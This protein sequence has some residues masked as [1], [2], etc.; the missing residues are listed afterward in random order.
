MT[1]VL[2]YEDVKNGKLSD[3]VG[4]NVPLFMQ[5]SETG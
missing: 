2:I 1:F 4:I 3:I 5:G